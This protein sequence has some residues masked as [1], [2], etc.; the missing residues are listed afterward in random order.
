[1][2]R[3]SGAIRAKVTLS[4]L[5]SHHTTSEMITNTR[6]SICFSDCLITMLV[7]ASMPAFPAA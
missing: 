5:N 3:Y 7:A 6:I 4:D 1:M 2:D